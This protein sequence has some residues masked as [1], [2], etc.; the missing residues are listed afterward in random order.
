MTTLPQAK[1]D[2]AEREWRPIDPKNGTV[3]LGC[4]LYNYEINFNAP[5]QPMGT[6]PISPS[7]APQNAVEMAREWLLQHFFEPTEPEKHW[8]P[9]TVEVC[10]HYRHYLCGHFNGGGGEHPTQK[11]LALCEYLIRTYSNAGDTVLDN[12]MG[13]G[14][15]GV[16]A[17]N[18]NRNFVGIEKD[19][20]YFAMAKTRL[21]SIGAP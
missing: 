20:S 16:A 21:K 6:P 18:E 19:S 3:G 8:T 5:A 7:P 15:T 10:E 1:I 11:P 12:V 17:V 13:S 4:A 9:G 2:A 14:T